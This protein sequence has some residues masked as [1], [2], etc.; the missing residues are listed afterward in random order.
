MKLIRCLPPP[1]SSAEFHSQTLP[2][3][4]RFGSLPVMKICTLAVL[5]LTLA[6]FIMAQAPPLPP[7]ASLVAGGLEGPRGL[8]FGPDGLLYVAEAGLGGL[9]LE[10]A[11]CPPVPEVGPYHGGLTARVSR[12]ET[13]GHRTTVIDHLPSAQSSL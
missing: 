11:G 12:I 13:N 4:Q 9:Q 5:Y 6:G 3:P 1:H 8:T 10:P 2:S 7:G